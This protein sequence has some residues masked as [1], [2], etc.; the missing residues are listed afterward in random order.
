[1]RGACRSG[2]VVVLY[3]NTAMIASAGAWLIISA[4]AA[5]RSR[6]LGSERQSIADE[7]EVWLKQQ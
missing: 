3:V 6:R 5:E 7:A 1:M 2:V 4:V